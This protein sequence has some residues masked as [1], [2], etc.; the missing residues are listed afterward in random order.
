[1]SKSKKIIGIDLGSY[2]SCVS[3]YEGSEIKIIPNSEGALTTPSFVA[4][5]KDGI[6]TGDPAKRQATVNPENTIFNIKRLMGKTYE[7]VKH[8]KRPYKIV[9]SNGRAAIETNGRVYSPEEISAMILQK[10]KKTAEDFLGEEVE[11]CVITVPAYFNSDERESTKQAGEIAGF[12]VERVISEPT[13]AILNINANP[14]KD[15]KCVVYDFGGQTFDCS[16]ITV[17][18]GIYEVISTN[19]DLDLG[20]SIIDE[21]LVDY[22][23]TEFKKDT[24]IDL[25]KDPMALQ[26]LFDAAE[27]AKIELSGCP[28]SEINLPYI[29]VLDGVPQHLVKKITK[30]L[31]E[32]M[33]DATI[34]R[35][36]DKTRE[37]IK[38]SGIKYSEFDE[39]Y[40]VGGS[41]RIPLVSDKLEKLFGKKPSKAL[42]PDT[43]VSSGSCIQGAVLSGDN[44]DI[45]LLDVNPIN[46]GIETM[47]GVFTVLIEENTT[48]PSSKEQ[49]FST[50]Q[51]NQPSVE[52]HILQGTRTMAKDNKSIGKFHL[53]GIMPAPKGTPQI[54][55]KCDMDSNG[56]LTVT[57]IDK[58]T[59]KQNS[60][61]IEG[62]TSLSKDEIEKMKNDAIKNADADKIAKEK[63]ELNNQAESLIYQTEKLLKENEDKIS[64]SNKTELTNALD[65]LNEAKKT[66]DLSKIGSAISKLQ[67]IWG[68]VSTEMY[69]AATDANMV[70][71]EPVT[72]D[73]EEVK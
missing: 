36:M 8:L 60:I 53:D 2:N 45:L 63:I 50:A 72:A 21:L 33:A 67:E 29:T 23:V 41:T 10:M 54:S 48:I 32:K 17:G 26:R 1:M 13:A 58:A 64:E 43:C 47:G 24:T 18:D 49:V 46:I 15:V 57:A 3:V 4:F 11:K 73:Y 9:N 28:E 68:R 61:R 16:V 27:K 34:E 25:R 44:T 14:N 40:L 12:K 5:T 66:D 51:D 65:E 42:N 20:G 52:V 7:Q 31:F 22:L 39:I 70:D 71:N 62:S 37:A 6:K 55:I 59:N 30:S 69:T 35:T 56:I 19:G 38:K